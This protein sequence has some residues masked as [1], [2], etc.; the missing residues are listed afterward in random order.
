MLW[1]APFFLFLYFLNYGTYF[2]SIPVLPAFCIA[3]ARLILEVPEMIESRIPMRSLQYGITSVLITLRNLSVGIFVGMANLGNKKTEAKSSKIREIAGNKG[4]ND[5][6]RNRDGEIHYWNEPL[7]GQSTRAKPKRRVNRFGCSYWSIFLF[8]VV[9]GIG[10]GSTAFLVPLDASRAQIQAA[11]FASGY[12]EEAERQNCDP[13]IQPSLLLDI[14]LC[15]QQY[16]Y[17][18]ESY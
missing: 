18:Q 10:L 12:I 17:S 3:L 7:S 15:I 14:L 16:Q 2:Y 9:A 1:V 6:I 5:R 11:A 8:L 13:Y 4:V